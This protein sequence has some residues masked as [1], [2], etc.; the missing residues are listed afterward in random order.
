LAYVVVLFVKPQVDIWCRQPR[1]SSPVDCPH[2]ECYRR[3][4]GQR[5]RGRC[6]RGGTCCVVSS[7]APAN[8]TYFVVGV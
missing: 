8:V 5:W 6:Q 4:Q 2:Q 1:R 3:D 7:A